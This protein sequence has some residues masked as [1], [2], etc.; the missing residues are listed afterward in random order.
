MSIVHH[1][2][3]HC[4]IIVSDIDE[5]LTGADPCNNNGTCINTAGGVDCNCAGTG[6]DGPTCDSGRLNYPPG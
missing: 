1:N 2:S 3:Q 6:Y 5:C 4:F